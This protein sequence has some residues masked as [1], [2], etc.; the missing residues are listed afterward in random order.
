MKE[1]KEKVER[2]AGDKM[3]RKRKNE[4]EIKRREME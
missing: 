1:T 3:E 4:K 2:N